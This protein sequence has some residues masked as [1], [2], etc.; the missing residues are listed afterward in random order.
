V[1]GSTSGV[2]VHL[3]V[4]MFN[5]WFYC[6]TSGVTVRLLVLLFNFWCHRSS[7]GVNV[8]LLVLL[9]NFWRYCSTFGVIIQLLLITALGQRKASSKTVSSRKN[10]MYFTAG[11]C[12]YGDEPLGS[13]KGEKLD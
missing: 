5:F 6:S 13:T 8:Q 11:F 3:L 9:F 4:L 12:E 7:S 10:A 2:T 1:L